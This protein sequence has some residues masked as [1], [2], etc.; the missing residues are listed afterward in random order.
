VRGKGRQSAQ[1]SLVLPKRAFDKDGKSRVVTL[2]G[3]TI[4]AFGSRFRPERLKQKRRPWNRSA[5][6]GLRLRI[7]TCAG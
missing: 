7:V 4:G 5:R 2:A 1:R 3:S 6:C